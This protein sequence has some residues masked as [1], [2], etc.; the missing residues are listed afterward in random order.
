[1]TIMLIKSVYLKPR[2][3]VIIAFTL[4]FDFHNKLT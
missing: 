1:M 2:Y 3:N 4:S